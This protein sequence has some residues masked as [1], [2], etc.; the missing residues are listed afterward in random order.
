MPEYPQMPEYPR[1]ATGGLCFTTHPVRTHDVC[2]AATPEDATALRMIEDAG[3]CLEALARARDD[4]RAR[5]KRASHHEAFGALYS[6]QC[7]AEAQQLVRESPAGFADGLSLARRI[8]W[9]SGHEPA[10]HMQRWRGILSDRGI[11]WS[12]EH[13]AMF[14][15]LWAEDAR[16]SPHPSTHTS[17]TIGRA[18]DDAHPHGVVTT[19][20]PGWSPFARPSTADPSP[21]HGSIRDSCGLGRV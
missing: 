19:P 10:A 12:P 8:A 5:G 20:V 11:G 15:Q 1:P 18:E 7:H 9:T 4:L 2:R 21:P 17:S 14:E 6:R 13:E 3:S 16:T